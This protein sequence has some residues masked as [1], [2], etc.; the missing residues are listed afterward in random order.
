MT[1]PRY[2]EKEVR[3]ILAR[4]V[5]DRGSRALNSAEGLTLAELKEVGAEVGIDGASLERAA[6]AVRN[7]APNRYAGIIGAP[8]SLEVNRSVPI[9]LDPE[10]MPDLVAVI[11]RGMGRSGELAEVHGM[12]EWRATGEAGE[13]VISLASRNGS[14]TIQGSADLRN[15]AIAGYT[16]VGIFSIIGA[17]ITFISAANNGSALGLLLAL[18]IVPLV[19][20]IVRTVL[21]RFVSGEERR[22]EE[23]VDQ[24]GQ[25]ILAAGPPEEGG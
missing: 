22:L 1:E 23:V 9:D 21:G 17:V 12:V 5:E 25:A 10:I 24:I 11:R 4:A 6:L 14:T 3:E 8:T 18:T 19:Y 2:S 13:R 7:T 20:M 15:A 16:P